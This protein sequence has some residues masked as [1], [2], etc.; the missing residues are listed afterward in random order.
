MPNCRRDE[1]SIAMDFRRREVLLGIPAAS[2]PWLPWATLGTRHEL[3]A[4]SPVEPAS[5]KIQTAIQG[6]CAWPNLQLLG[7]G[8]ILALIFNQ[9][10][11]GLWE[12][13]LDCWASEDGGRT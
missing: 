1:Y 7:G 11:H 8:T 12:G 5:I 6:V 3:I 10:C 9:P 4:A 13:D 2:A